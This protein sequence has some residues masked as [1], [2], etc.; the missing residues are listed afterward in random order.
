MFYVESKYYRT[1]V[2]LNYKEDIFEVITA[3]GGHMGRERH[4]SVS[5]QLAKV[6]HIHHSSQAQGP[7][8]L[9]GPHLICHSWR[10][11]EGIKNGIRPGNAALVGKP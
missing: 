7:T 9:T 10:K 3:Y 1:D 6:S 8:L 11:A 2:A 4:S 5:L